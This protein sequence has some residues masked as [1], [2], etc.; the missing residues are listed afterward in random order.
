MPRRPHHPHRPPVAYQEN[1][2]GN[3]ITAEEFAFLRAVERYQRENR[4]RYP[5]FRELLYVLHLLGYRKVGPAAAA[6]IEVL[7]PLAVALADAEK[8]AASP[9]GPPETPS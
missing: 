6:D 8:P 2:A 1:F 9:P 3:S 5:S 4:R 7:Y